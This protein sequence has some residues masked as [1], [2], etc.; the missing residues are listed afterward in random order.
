MCWLQR[1]VNRQHRLLLSPAETAIIASG[2]LNQLSVTKCQNKIGVC[3]R[4]KI[5]MEKRSSTLYHLRTNERG[6]CVFAGQ[7]GNSKFSTQNPPVY[8]EAYL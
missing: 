4:P 6:L 3:A 8:S 1:N 7:Q 5:Q 2:R